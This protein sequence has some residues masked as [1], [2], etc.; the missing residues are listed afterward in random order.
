MQTACN[1]KGLCIYEFSWGFNT[2]SNLLITL[3]CCWPSSPFQNTNPNMETSESLIKTFVTQ[4]TYTNRIWEIQLDMADIQSNK[5]RRLT[6]N[7]LNYFLS[8]GGKSM[9]AQLSKK[10]IAWITSGRPNNRN[11]TIVAT[12]NSSMHLTF[13]VTWHTLTSA[14]QWIINEPK[15]H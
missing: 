10:A 14:T 12:W 3:S 7:T 13:R 8:W 5:D 15:G 9:A 4:Q 2:V 6:F 11:H 1:V